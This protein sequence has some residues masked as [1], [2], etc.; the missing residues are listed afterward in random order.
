MEEEQVVLVDASDNAIGRAP[1]LEAHRRGLLHRAVS[2][3]VFRPSGELLLQR[4]AREKYHS[5]GLWANTC[6]GHPR[7]GEQAEQA[8]KRRLHDEMGLVCSLDY[9]FSFVYRAAL[10]GE[11]IEHELDHVFVGTTTDEPLPD[12][13]EVEEWRLVFPV[14]LARELAEAPDTFAA[15]FSPALQGVL[16]RRS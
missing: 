12:V 6:C 14:A 13:R 5:G 1:K 4:R 8:A 11:L 16:S 10:A 2:V 15:W 3:F 7:P 9:A